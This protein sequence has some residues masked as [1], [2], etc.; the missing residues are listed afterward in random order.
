LDFKLGE[1]WDEIEEELH[2]DGIRPVSPD[3]E[4]I[5]IA[6]QVVRKKA[7]QV[8]QKQTKVLKKEL[9]VSQLEF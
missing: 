4:S 7:T 3:V 6:R 9:E 2:Y 8:K 5:S 1:V